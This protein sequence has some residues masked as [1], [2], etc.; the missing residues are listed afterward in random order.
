LSPMWPLSFKKLIQ[1]VCGS[2]IWRQPFEKVLKHLTVDVNDEVQL[3][4][5]MTM[6]Y[7]QI[8]AKP[9]EHLE[10][11]PQGLETLESRVIQAR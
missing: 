4:P 2:Q 6:G 11:P 8:Q 9:Q 7:C 1:K 10:A 3:P 5:F